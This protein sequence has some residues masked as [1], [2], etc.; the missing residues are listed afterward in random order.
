MTSSVTITPLVGLG[1]ITDGTDL[2]AALSHV[3]GEVT[4]PDGSSGLAEGDIIVVSSKIVSKAEGRSVPASDRERAIDEETVALVASK[5]TPQGLTRIVR[6][7]TGLVLAAAGVD[8]SDV[9]GDQ[10]LLLPVDP[11]A[12]ARA[13]RARIAALQQTQVGVIITDTLGRAWRDGLSDAAIGV[14]GITPMADHR[15]LPDR[16]GRPMEATVIAIADEI[17]SAADLVKGK[18]LGVPA[19]V[20]RGL[21]HHVTSEDGPG[22]RAMVRPESEDLFTLGTAEALA[23]GRREAV[24]ARRT[25]RFFDDRPVA[26]DIIEAAVA[27]AV[28][29]PSPHHTTP[30]HF[31]VVDD[32]TM[33]TRLLDD[34]RDAWIEDLRGIDHF[35][36]ESITRRI[37]RGDVLRRA[38]A[39]ILPFLDLAVS[40][41]H[42]PDERRRS[43]E[44]DLFLL[45]GGAAVQNLMVAL[46]AY[47]VGSAWISS[48]V[49]CAETVQQT[50]DL[51]SSWQPLGAVAVGYPGEEARPR[52]ARDARQFL[53][54]A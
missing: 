3:V 9:P 28:T 2:A 5:Q 24:S 21:A 53:H 48:T 30:W 29:A 36:E 40:M 6:T 20:I 45:A 19:A 12:S 52:P 50:L 31:V 10:V 7:R 26:D 16:E 25:V 38:P 1:E 22:A 39:L 27:A 34:M 44:R 4:W 15:G 47:D 17:A 42:Y 46:A 18:A 32:M 41:H 23:Q 54:R 37:A 35:S 49:F 8:A 51:P 13:L 43:A 11:D 14:A 33:R